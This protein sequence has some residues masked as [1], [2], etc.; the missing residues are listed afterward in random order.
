MRIPVNT[1]SHQYEVV[2]GNNILT[3]AMESLHLHLPK[4]DKIIVFTD[5]NV[6]KAHKNYFTESFPYP[7]EVF[8]MPA[9]EECKSFDNYKEANSFLIDNKCTRKSL[10]IALGGGAVGDLSGF[11]A[12]TYMRGIPFI[13]VPTTI[14][15]HD[16]AVGGKTAINHPEGKNLIGAFY[17]P[18]AVIYDTRFLST[19]SEREVRSGMA[20]VIKHAMI[21]DEIW[22]QELLSI[23]SITSIADE[24]LAS[25]LKAGIEVK[26]N[27]VAEDETEQSVR[28]YL[29]LGHTYGH[30]IEAAAGYGGLAHGEAVVIGL[31]YALILSERYGKISREFTKSFLKFAYSNGYPF[32]AVSNY[33]FDTLEPFLVKDKKVEYG[34]LQFVLLNTIGEPFIQTIEVS[35]CR[36]VDLEYRALLMEVCK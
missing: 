9:G 2:I 34:Q 26:A 23:Q 25:Y 32:D 27:I 31:V 30:A 18:K 17:Q 16:S 12:A 1:A 7:F 8:V 15:A 13:Q 28:K 20:E 33:S 5:E 11:V 36:E 22:L 19:L 4:E 24:Q 21:S 35:E 29:N 3:S 14:L 6:W 10:L